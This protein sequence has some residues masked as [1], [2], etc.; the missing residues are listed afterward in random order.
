MMRVVLLA[1]F[2]L[3]VATPARA[4]V[5]P[6]TATL[7]LQYGYTVVSVAFS[8]SGVATVNGSG[9]GAHLSQIA[10]AS[11]TISGSALQPITDPAAAPVQGLILDV[12]NAAGT[13]AETTGGTLR[14]QLGLLGVLKVC[15]FAPCAS[16]V[17][18]LSV[19]QTPVGLSGPPMTLMNGAV[20]VTVTG[21]PWTTGT[22]AIGALTRMGFAHG[23]VSGT[24]STAQLGGVLRLVTPVFVSTN[25]STVPTPAFASLTLHFVPEPV[26]ALLLGAGIVALGA[27]GRRNV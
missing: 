27:M 26:T 22:A 15:L 18:N 10:F 19:P 23:P 5:L 20:N 2:A 24:S 25:V 21:A 6:F 1:A 7:E 4:A 9:A 16:A 17:A 11:G 13:I 12:A 3:A 14:G 8:D